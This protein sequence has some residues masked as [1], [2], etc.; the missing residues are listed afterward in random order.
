M[1]KTVPPTTSDLFASTASRDTSLS[2]LAERLRPNSIDEIVGQERLIGSGRALRRLLERQELPSLIL[3]GPPG[4]GKTTLARVLAKHINAELES[5]SAV[6]SGVKELRAVVERATERRQYHR[7]RTVLFV[8][9]IHRFNKAQQDAL[10]PHVEL[11]L[12]T[13]IGATTE[14]PSFEVIAALLS[15]CKVFVLE[16]LAQ[17]DII[18]L[19][20]RALTDFERGLGKHNISASQDILELI[21]QGADGDAR[22]ALN[23][24]EV[25]VDLAVQAK[26]TTLTTELIEE[27]AQQ[28]TILYDKAG[29]QHYN[30]VSAFIKSMRGS[31]PDAAVYWLTRM[32]EANEDPRFILRRMVILASEDIGN[33]DP[34][35]LNVAVNALQAFEFIG[36]PEGVLPMTQAATYL[37]CAPKSN[38]V[39]AAYGSA[40][41]DVQKHGALTVPL[42][43]RNAPTKLMKNIGYGDGYK[44]PHAFD[45]N[46]VKEEYLPEELVGQIYYKPSNQ[47]LERDINKRLEQLRNARGYRKNRNP[48]DKS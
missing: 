6:M 18:P 30:V 34:M 7:L 8:D 33:A 5:L 14:N 25:A 42:K 16:P 23:T 3:W 38:A 39:I 37:A 13:L 15:R 11:G 35:A 43:L 22:R 36:L 32:L 26:V 20:V 12:V 17:D 44:Y 21:A 41:A 19:L 27:A 4:C 24:I 40:K 1:R 2:P 45:G 48:K 31:D 9:E 47:G 46:Y 29:E 10:L 28:K